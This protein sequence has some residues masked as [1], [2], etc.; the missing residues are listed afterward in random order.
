MRLS[1]ERAVKGLK[2]DS[3]VGV[4][5]NDTRSAWRRRQKPDRGWLYKPCYFFKYSEKP[6]E[7]SKD[8][9]DKIYSIYVIER[10]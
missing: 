3:A 8:G 4:R 7:C 6:L 1:G 2:V 9:S 10:L 5:E